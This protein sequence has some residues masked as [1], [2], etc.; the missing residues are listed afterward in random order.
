MTTEN[1]WYFGFGSLIN[2]AT[3]PGNHLMLPATLQGFT[4]EWSYRSI[5][6]YANVTAL[7]ILQAQGR[8]TTGVLVAEPL[9]RLASL[10]E[11]EHGYVRL[12][13]DYRQLYFDQLS[14]PEKILLQLKKEKIYLYQACETHYFLADENY[15]ILQSYIDV[16][17][18]GIIEMFDYQQAVLAVRNWQ[19]FD[20]PIANDRNQPIYPR[21]INFTSETLKKIDNVLL[22]AYAQ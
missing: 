12:E 18:A 6:S 22:E 13:I 5:G 2:K 1:F 10:D 21:A 7:N 9:E 17:I 16:V 3:R 4:R 11:R 14:L 8:Q 19:G 20:R 15:P